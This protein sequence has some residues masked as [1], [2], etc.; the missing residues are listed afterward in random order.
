[1]STTPRSGAGCRITALSWSSDC[2]GTS[3]RQKAYCHAAYNWPHDPWFGSRVIGMRFDFL[4]AVQDA[5]PEFWC[6]GFQLR[7]DAGGL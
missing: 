3:S 1:M 2:E 6:A 7:R 4:V 5:G